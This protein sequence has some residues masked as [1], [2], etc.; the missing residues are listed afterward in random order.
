MQAILKY[1]KVAIAWLV[2]QFGDVKDVCLAIGK[3]VVLWKKQLF[4]LAVGVMLLGLVITLL[5]G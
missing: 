5:G 2:A 1:P 4:K 3:F